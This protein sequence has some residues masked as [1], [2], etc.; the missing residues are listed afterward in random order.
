MGTKN[1]QVLTDEEYS[2]L[3]LYPAPNEDGTLQEVADG[4][5][6]ESYWHEGQPDALAQGIET[7]Q[8]QRFF[9]AIGRKL[10]LPWLNALTRKVNADG[11]SEARKIMELRTDVPHLN[12]ELDPLVI[13]SATPEQ[14]D[15]ETPAGQMLST[16]AAIMMMKSNTAAGYS[17]DAPNRRRF[18]I[19]AKNGA[20]YY[21]NVQECAMLSTQTPIAVFKPLDDYDPQ[22]D[23]AVSCKALAE[24]FEEMS[25]N[26]LKKA[27][28][29]GAFKG[30]QGPKGEKGDDGAAGYTPQKGVD[31]FTPADKAELVA[32][33]LE[34]FTDVSEVG[35]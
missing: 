9:D 32:G 2:V 20:I 24:A 4:D 35:L 21:V 6:L 27:K 5:K 8:V 31:Y 30:E 7:K 17:E 15:I 23:R 22:S 18:V 14:E 11:A 26:V 13:L 16:T 34:S 12:G 28:D 33:V 3:T 25:E 29:S 10:F 19:D 1:A